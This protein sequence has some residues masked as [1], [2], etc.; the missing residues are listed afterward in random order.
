[1]KVILDT[2]ILLSAL[3]SPHGTADQIYRAWRRGRFDLVTS[4]IQ[5][6]ELKRASRYPKLSKILRPHD[7]GTMVNNL[8]HAIVLD[9]LHAPII[10]ALDP[11]DTFLIAMAVKSAADYLITGDH[12]AGLLEQKTI[13]KT[14]IVTAKFFCIHVLE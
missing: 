10:E 6:D 7:V 2:N 11:Y 8:H 14:Q 13:E 1:M 12:R 9:H 4:K 3:I 5:L